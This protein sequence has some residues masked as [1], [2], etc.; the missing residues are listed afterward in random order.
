M[1]GG[2]PRFSP[3]FTGADLLRYVIGRPVGFVYG[4]I[5]LCGA[6]FHA[7]RLP[8]GL[9]T[10]AGAGTPRTDALQPLVR[11][12]WP[13]TRTKFGLFPFRSPLLGESRLISFPPGTE[14]FQFPGLPPHAYVFSMRYRRIAS[15][16]FPHS[17]TS[18]ST[19]GWQLPGAFRSHP[20]PSSPLST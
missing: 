16:G 5:A 10:S 7:L 2:P 17:D 8:A 3:R 9:V 18:G 1:E 11:N 13:L 6:R 4:T 12:A 19:S 14:M 20:R 15:G